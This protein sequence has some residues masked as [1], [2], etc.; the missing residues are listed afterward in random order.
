MVDLINMTRETVEELLVTC[1]TDQTETAVEDLTGY[2]AKMQFRNILNNKLAITLSTDGPTPLGSTLTI[3]AM[4]GQ[5]TAWLS[6]EDTK[7]ISAGT[8]N[9]DLA[10][11]LEYETTRPVRLQIK[12]NDYVTEVDS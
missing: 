2:T 3:D 4:A 6:T 7:A 5:I 12:F 8:Y 11:T 10:L 9:M 1:Y